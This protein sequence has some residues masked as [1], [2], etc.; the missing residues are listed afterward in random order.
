MIG[1]GIKMLV[2]NEV[3]TELQILCNALSL[4]TIKTPLKFFTHV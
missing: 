2:L 4:W 1:M 3:T